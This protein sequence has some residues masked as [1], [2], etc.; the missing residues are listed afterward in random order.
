VAGSGQG[1]PPEVLQAA[2][3]EMATTDV[4]V[5]GNPQTAAQCGLRWDKWHSCV[6]LRW[7]TLNQTVLHM[8]NSR[9]SL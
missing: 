9:C 6:L 2:Y 7:A 5:P 8:C 4:E 3:K 1:A